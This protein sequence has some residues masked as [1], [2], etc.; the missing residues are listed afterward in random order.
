MVASQYHNCSA[1]I[2]HHTYPP[3]ILI[4]CCLHKDIFVTN[5]PF[6]TL[7]TQELLMHQ[8]SDCV[9]MYHEITARNT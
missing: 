6:A 7:Y 5:C 9:G 3:I 1:S 4:L 8:V 2:Q